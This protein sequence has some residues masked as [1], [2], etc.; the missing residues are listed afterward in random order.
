MPN[1][2]L[3]L[4]AS[5]L[6]QGPAGMALK[7]DMRRAQM[8][9]RISVIFAPAF[10]GCMRG[11]FR[12]Q[13]LDVQ[14]AVG[15]P[16]CSNVWCS[17]AAHLMRINLASRR[18]RHLPSGAGLMMI[19]QTQRCLNWIQDDGWQEAHNKRSNSGHR[20]HPEAWLR[21]WTAMQYSPTNALT[22]VPSGLCI[23]TC[24]RM[25]RATCIRSCG[26]NIQRL[27]AIASQPF[28]KLPNHEH[29]SVLIS[30]AG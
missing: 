1:I 5:A 14:Y 24:F 29:R 20:G 26:T 23:P 18:K 21:M 7:G 30:Q 6:P 28:C 9:W 25:L 2:L 13:M 10:A 19:R 17:D 15:H 8:P 22:S 3:M 12:S 11:S 4:L 27:S 16:C